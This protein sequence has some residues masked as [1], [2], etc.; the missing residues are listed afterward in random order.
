LQGIIKME[1]PMGHKSRFDNFPYQAEAQR[2]LKHSLWERGFTYRKLAQLLT[3]RGL[4]HTKESLANKVYRGS[5][6]AA[7]LVL[8]LELMGTELRVGPSA[9]TNGQRFSPSAE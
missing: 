1:D 7:F 8:C 2:L 5:Y 3:E 4:P 6:S 9:T